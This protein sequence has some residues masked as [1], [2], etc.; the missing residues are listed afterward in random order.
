MNTATLGIVDLGRGPQLTDSRITVQDIVP[1]WKLR[2]SDEQIL[3]EM[4]ALRLEQLQVLLEYIRTHYEE[5]MAVDRRI[6]ARNKAREQ[7]SDLE[8][9]QRQQRL[10]IARTRI[11]GS[12]KEKA[13]D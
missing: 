5:V 7:A 3:E 6:E 12:R 2:F 10:E 8:N 1:Y 11:L 13:G 4:P 9:I